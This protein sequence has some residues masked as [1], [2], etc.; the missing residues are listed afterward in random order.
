MM[1]TNTLLRRRNILRTIFGLFTLTGILFAFQACY[2][3]PQDFGMDFLLTGKVISGETKAGI[4]HIRVGIVGHGGYQFTETDGTFSFYTER[5]DE[6]RVTFTDM[7]GELNGSYQPLDTLVTCPVD[8]DFV[9]LT[10]E[11]K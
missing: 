5:T 8:R 9:D 7:D 6:L 2:G 4:P 11:L 1:K 10:V 3:P